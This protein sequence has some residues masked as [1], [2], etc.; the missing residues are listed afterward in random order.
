M[1]VEK[2][3]TIVGRT[4]NGRPFHP[5]TEWCNTL[6][7]HYNDETGLHRT[8]AIPGYY[9]TGKFIIVFRVG[10]DVFDLRNGRNN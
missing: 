1:K 4:F 8:D 2:N 7:Q 5:S 6:R 9:G 3:S 10:M